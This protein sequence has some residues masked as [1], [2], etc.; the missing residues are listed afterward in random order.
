MGAKY[1]LSMPDGSEF[2]VNDLATLQ[3]L[4][5]EQRISC[6]V[7]V[8]PLNSVKWQALKDQFDLSQ[9]PA[10]APGTSGVPEYAAAPD[11]QGTEYGFNAARDLGLERPSNRGARTAGVLFLA[12]AALSFVALIAIVALGL[13]PG[14]AILPVGILTLDI[15]IGMNLIRGEWKR[16]AMYRLAVGLVLVALLY[17]LFFPGPIAYFVIGSQIIFLAGFVILLFGEYISIMR[18]IFGA[19]VV[20][21]AWVT[22]FGG[23][24]LVTKVPVLR[25]ATEASAFRNNVRHYA[26]A[27]KRF[28]DPLIRHVLVDLPDGW[29]LLRPDNPVLPIPQARMIAVHLDS[30][31]NTSLIIEYYSSVTKIVSIDDY[32]D[33]QRK[34]MTSLSKTFSE[35]KREK[36]YFGDDSSERMEA[37]WERNGQKFHG[38][39][40]VCK[41]D[42]Y[43][44]VL[45]GW[46]NEGD[47]DKAFPRFQE[48]EKSF[49][50]PSSSYWNVN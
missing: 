1:K 46:C 44:F 17:P 7:L 4:Y 21:F 33:L 38:W 43:Y 24:V 34:T 23:S 29:L 14:Q 42:T 26:L 19:G 37:T 39:Y 25:R 9:W 13:Q 49:R 30:G 16:F 15:L 35:I 45:S 20:A 50:L 18:T 32:L 28:D 36:T 2:I 41:I 6:D 27:T 5:R 47:Q 3:R 40:T 11:I 48:L 10:A 22:I 12:N 31:C 8:A